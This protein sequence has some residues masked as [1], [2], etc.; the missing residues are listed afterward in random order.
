MMVA[1][2]PPGSRLFLDTN[3]LLTATDEGRNG[4]YRAT[5][6]IS[7]APGEG[8]HLFISGQ[9]LREYLVVATRPQEMN[10]LGLNLPAARENVEAFMGFLVILDEPAS[11]VDRLLKL[12]AECSVT[13]KRIHD[14]GIV[15][16]MLEHNIHNLVT[17]NPGDFAAFGDITVREL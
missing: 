3:V 14:A 2:T 1:E 5:E 16:T 7:Q 15:A 9:V 11:M 17:A 10:G 13:G 8:V 12:I 4:H 6:L